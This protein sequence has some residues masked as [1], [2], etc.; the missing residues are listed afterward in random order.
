MNLLL[1]GQET[2]RL[3]FRK[4]TP[5][6]FETWLPFH[7]NPLSTEHWFGENPDPAIACQDWFNRIFHRYENGTGG[8]NA[9]ISKETG[10]F[11]GQGGLLVQEVDGEKELEIGYS[12]LPKYWRQGFA[13]EAAQQCKKFAFENDLSESLI[14]II[15]IEN[16]PSQK[17]ALAMGMQL[18]KT[19]EY[20]G[21]P[22]HIFRVRR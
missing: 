5:D 18:D 15:H 11:I 13:T 3:K 16:I 4:L 1:E 14:S 7:Q 19:T 9:L 17:V 21:N 2:E 6:D 8:L 20:K 10:D 22:T 12:I